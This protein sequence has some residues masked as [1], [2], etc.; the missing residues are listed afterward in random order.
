METQEEKLL[1][2]MAAIRV[3]AKGK[4]T[5]I[6]TAKSGRKYYSLQARRDGRNVTRY[7][8]TEKLEAVK[9]AT[10]NHRRF[11]AL[12]ERYVALCEARFDL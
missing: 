3:M 10:A 2:A 8:P 9:E 7:V 4:V 1:A 5:V 6:R 11:M 12:V